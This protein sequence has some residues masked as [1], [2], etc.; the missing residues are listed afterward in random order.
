MHNVLFLLC[1][2]I[3]LLFSIIY[4]IIV[5]SLHNDQNNIKNVF[6]YYNMCQVVCNVKLLKYSRI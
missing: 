4:E 5:F 1:N 3:L 6:E 2:I